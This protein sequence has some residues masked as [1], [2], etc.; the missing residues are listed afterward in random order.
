MS[1]YGVR[2]DREWIDRIRTTQDIIR[3][4]PFDKVPIEYRALIVQQF[5]VHVE[6]FRS[7]LGNG[8]PT[9]QDQRRILELATLALKLIEDADKMRNTPSASGI[10]RARL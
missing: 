6:N 7:N 4:T 2:Y 9:F 1:Q 3:T 8:N 10:A 5:N